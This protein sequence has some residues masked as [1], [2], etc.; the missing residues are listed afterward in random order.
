MIWVKLWR[1]IEHKSDYVLCGYISHWQWKSVTLKKSVPDRNQSAKGTEMTDSMRNSWNTEP[2][3]GLYI[4]FIYLF[5][6]NFDKAKLQIH[7]AKMYLRWYIDMYYSWTCISYIVDLMRSDLLDVF[8]A[9]NADRTSH[10]KNIHH[11]RLV[12]TSKL[13][14]LPTVARSSTEQ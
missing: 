13:K 7:L 9:T 14:S 12:A 10:I 2:K 8:R 4:H 11:K 6:L 3:L 5:I 1:K